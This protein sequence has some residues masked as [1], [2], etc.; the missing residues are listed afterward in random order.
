MSQPRIVIL[1]GP[2]GAGKSTASQLI[3]RDELGI[4]DFINA[5]TIARGLSAYD[6]E[7]V[8]LESGRIMLERLKK[9]IT[10]IGDQL[11]RR[12]RRVY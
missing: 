9:Q 4:R 1:A 2:N 7:S 5:D 12:W 11:F 8:A 6:V 3:I 10:G